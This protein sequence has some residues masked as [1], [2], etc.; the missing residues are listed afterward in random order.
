MD[1]DTRAAQMETPPWPG[2]TTASLETLSCYE[3]GSI[4]CIVGP[5]LGW[6]WES[7]QGLH[8]LGLNEALMWDACPLGLP[9]I[10]HRSS[11]DGWT[12]CGYAQGFLLGFL[13]LAYDFLRVQSIRTQG[14]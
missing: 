9:E 13:R 7:K 3:P 4:L 14:T 11:Y 1:I 6:T 12:G 8:I 10:V 2:L 5:H